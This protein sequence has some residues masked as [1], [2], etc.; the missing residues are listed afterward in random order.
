MADEEEPVPTGDAIAFAPATYETAGCARY[1]LHQ[2]TA[3][4]RDENHRRRNVCAPF[5]RII[6]QT[7][8]SR[9]CRL[10]FQ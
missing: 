1:V 8:V 9:L 4:R 2:R 5:H 6:Y 10:P 7:S 3:Y